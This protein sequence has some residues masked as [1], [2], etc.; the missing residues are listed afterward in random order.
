MSEIRDKI[1]FIKNQI[2]KIGEYRA[3]NNFNERRNMALAMGTKKEQ[4]LK[5]FLGYQLTAT[6]TRN[7]EIVLDP[8]YITL[9]HIYYNQLRETNRFH[10]G[11][12]E[13]DEKYFNQYKWEFTTKILPI[14]NFYVKESINV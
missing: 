2:K 8:E 12:K 11:S 10:L 1:R 13:A 9:L 4:F 6:I 3:L 14:I 5:P 7:P